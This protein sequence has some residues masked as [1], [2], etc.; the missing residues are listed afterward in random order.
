MNRETLPYR[1]CAGF[2]LINAE[3][4]VFVGQRIDPSAHGFWQMPQGGIDQGEDVRAAALRELEEE[5]G[6]GA[7]LVEVIAPASR[8]I[9]YDLP[10][11]LLG[12][13]WKG[14]YRGQEQHWFLG[15]FLGTDANIDLNAHEPAEFN[16]WRW[17]APGL[18]PEVIVPFKRDVYEAVL[19]EFRDLI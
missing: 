4:L 17:I 11:E 9:A 15:R 1:P 6:I 2:M 8:T 14:K 3:G 7:H 10:D 16:E 12:K 18:L 5:T 13:V 19:A